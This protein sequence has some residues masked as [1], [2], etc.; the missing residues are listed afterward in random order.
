MAIESARKGNIVRTLLA[1]RVEDEER[2]V[3]LLGKEFE[4]GDVF[5]GVDFILFGEF[6]R[7]GLFEG[8]LG[9]ILDVVGYR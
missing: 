9:R 7:E 2:G 5:E 6:L 1:V 3:V 4:G 8:V